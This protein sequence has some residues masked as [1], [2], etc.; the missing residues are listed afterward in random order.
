MNLEKINFVQD[1]LTWKAPGNTE[2]TQIVIFAMAYI[3]LHYI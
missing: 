2:P 3:V 1:N